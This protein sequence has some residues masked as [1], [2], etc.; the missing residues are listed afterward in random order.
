MKF[1]GSIPL[2]R[3]LHTASLVDDQMVIIGGIEGDYKDKSFNGYNYIYHLRLRSRKYVALKREDVPFP[4]IEININNT[5]FKAYKFI[6]CQSGKIEKLLN[7]NKKLSFSYDAKIFEEIL[8]FMYGH[9]LNNIS[10]E[11]LIKLLEHICDLVFFHE[12]EKTGKSGLEKEGT[13]K[14]N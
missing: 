13:A 12:C 5:I 10:K 14:V 7:S 1:E 3:M 4:D 2:P 9:R 11:K 6:I 8:N